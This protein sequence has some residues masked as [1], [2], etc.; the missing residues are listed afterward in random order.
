MDW[1]QEMLKRLDALAEKL[2]TTAQYLWHVLV[3]QGIA[4]GLV[5]ATTAVAFL[6]ATIIGIVYAKK[7]VKWLLGPDGIEDVWFPAILLIGSCIGMTIAALCYAQSAI[8]EL[9]NPEYWALQELLK[10]VGK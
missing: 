10:A 7:L 1:K 3:K 8:L 6:V 4:M 5:D 2:G 9:Y